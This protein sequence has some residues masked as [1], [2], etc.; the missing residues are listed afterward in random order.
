MSK[1]ALS[2]VAVVAAI[3]ASAS[4]AEAASPVLTHHNDNFRTGAY[5]TEQTFSPASVAARGLRLA[6]WRPVDGAINSQILY[7]P[8]MRLEG[9]VLD[10]V[11]VATTNG[12]VYAYD[13]NNSRAS[14]TAEGLLWR[15]SLL[16]R[17]ESQNPG[18][19]FGVL[20]TPVI[21][22]SRSSLYV[23]TRT[24]GTAGSEF[25]LFDL[26]LHT[27]H[28]KQ[29]RKVE[30]PG[31]IAAFQNQRPALLLDHAMI[32]AAFGGWGGEGD[33]EYHGW[34]LRFSVD[35]LTLQG[36]FN[37]TPGFSCSFGAERACCDLN[38]PDRSCKLPGGG[39]GVWQGGG[40]PAADEDGNVYVLTGNG[41]F[42]PRNREYGDSVLKLGTTANQ[43]GLLSHY[44]PVEAK[45]LHTCDLDLGA[46]GPL[47][48][49]G[50][51]RVICGGKTGILYSLRR[52][53]LQLSPQALVGGSDTYH[54]ADKTCWWEGGPHLHGTPAFWQGRTG[55]YVF[56]W[57]EQDHLKRFALEPDGRLDPHPR[58]GDLRGPEC[59]DATAHHGPPG[60]PKDRMCP[61]PGGMLS[62][63]A[64]GDR[65]GIVWATVPVST[66]GRPYFTPA[67]LPPPGTLAAFDA[68]TMGR[69]WSANLPNDLTGG[70][71]LLGKWTPPT[72]VDGKLFVATS[73]ARADQV[74]RFLVYELAPPSPQQ[75]IFYKTS[76]GTLH[77][78]F[79]DTT[80]GTL[81]H[82]DWTQR[83]G[84]PRVA[85][86]I[87]TMVTAGQQHVFYRDAVGHVQHIFWDA[88]TSRLS[89]DDWTEKA[90][91]PPAGGGLATMVTPGQ[92]HVFYRSRDGAV[93]HIF[94][95]ASSN[96]FFHDNWTLLTS[97]PVA[98]GDPSSM[99]TPGQQ[100]VF[101]RDRTGH[102]Q[103]LFWDEA[104]QR[105]HRDDWTKLARAKKAVS[106]VATMVTQ[107]QQHIFYRTPGGTIQH[108]FWDETERRL[109][110]DDW[111]R[112]GVSRAAGEISTMTTPGQQHIFFR[113]RDGQVEHVLWD[114][115]TRT[116]GHDNWTERAHSPTA[117]GNVATLTTPGQQHVFYRAAD[118]SMQHIFWTDDTGTLLN[119]NWTLRTGAPAGID[120]PTALVF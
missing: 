105:L 59:A 91:A 71:S 53:D 95:Q 4:L 19:P 14:G 29:R 43:W 67:G 35:S 61:M 58:A 113:R 23:M 54:P 81:L 82:D 55:R 110:Q 5:L 60:P 32:Y 90:H 34:V 56:V 50:L 93:R 86:D 25:W 46:G 20:S 45:E 115:A 72:V 13:S 108:I 3:L 96:T 38:N 111:T 62:I 52:S 97:A 79:W 84:A 48:V 16:E 77:H 112:A 64:D 2:T 9:R 57:A 106:N 75:H 87:A 80:S 1:L 15:R 24:R 18:A 101:Y 76:G 33:H 41:K 100:H 26:D 65:S 117:T 85:G 103:H 37:T 47:V 30:A 49:P 89:H 109:V 114:A 73:P 12:T 17:D 120:D 36:A 116:F 98:A 78:V 27:G 74:G 69:L 51:D 70:V 102:A 7:V 11:F 92:Q 22:L 107:G 104:T 68:E 42:D 39:A 99:A 83:T 88:G 31:F 28:V 119:D 6:F 66:P 8:A 21:D 118:G 44:A 10:V 94:W 40:G 63:S